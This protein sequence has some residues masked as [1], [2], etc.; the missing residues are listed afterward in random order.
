[1][2]GVDEIAFDVNTILFCILLV[3]ENVHQQCDSDILLFDEAH[4][5]A[6]ELQALS[7]KPHNTTSIC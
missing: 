1:M 3:V 5:Q 4:F 6:M 2:G 7:W